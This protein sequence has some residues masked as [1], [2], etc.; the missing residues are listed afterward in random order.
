[1]SDFKNF[2]ISLR[3]WSFS[4]SVAP[5]L[6]T[7]AVLKKEFGFELQYVNSIFLILAFTI[8]HSG[9]NLLNSYFDFKNKVDRRNAADRT[10]VDNLITE[11]QCKILISSAFVIF[12]LFVAN[13][14]LK[15]FIET[16]GKYFS[17]KWTSFLTHLEV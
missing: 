9:A 12:G 6:L 16:R 17:Q 4:A 8:L 15:I 14:C 11:N 10:L 3:V 1:M 13:S 5:I 7:L 2:V